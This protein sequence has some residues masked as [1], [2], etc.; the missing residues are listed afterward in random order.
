[1]WNEYYVPLLFQVR[2]DDDLKL[3]MSRS[4]E[5]VQAIKYYKLSLSNH[6]ISELMHFSLKSWEVCQIAR[7]VENKLIAMVSTRNKSG[8]TTGINIINHKPVS[9][10]Q[11]NW[12]P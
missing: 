9:G 6:L 3:N 4:W 12:K 1:M 7:A 2:D 5:T 11:I 10:L 8:K